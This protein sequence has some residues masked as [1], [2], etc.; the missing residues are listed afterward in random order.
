[1]ITG[2]IIRMTMAMITGTTTVT[3][4]DIPEDRIPPRRFGPWEAGQNKRTGFP[5]V[6]HD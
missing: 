1:M 3:I 4:T 6:Q 2:T 5:P